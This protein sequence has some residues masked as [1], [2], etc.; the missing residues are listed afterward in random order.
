MRSIITR[1]TGPGKNAAPDAEDSPGNE[2]KTWFGSNQK[3]W[4][5]PRTQVTCAEAMKRLIDMKS[6]DAQRYANFLT[7]MN[8]KFWDAGDYLDC[9]AGTKNT[10]PTWVIVNAATKASDLC[11]LEPAKNRAAG[12]DSRLSRFKAAVGTEP[13]LS[14]AATFHAYYSALNNTAICTT[15]VVPEAERKEYKNINNGVGTATSPQIATRLGSTTVSDYKSF[16]YDIPSV[17][18]TGKEITLLYEVALKTDTTTITT[19][20]PPGGYAPSTSITTTDVHAMW[21]GSGGNLDCV[22]MAALLHQ[23]PYKSDWLKWMQEHKSAASSVASSTKKPSSE[24]LKPGE[25]SGSSGDGTTPK[26]EDQ[27]NCKIDYI[28]WFICPVVNTLASMS[29]GAR[30]QLINMLTVDAKSILGDTS[31]GSVYSYWSKIRDYANILFVV[32]FLF[33]IYSQMTGYGL[34]NY[35]IKRMLPKLIIGVIVVNASFYIC[36]LLVDLSNVVGSSAFNFV[37]TTAVG[38][39]PA[40]EWSNSDSGWINKI[41][42]LALVLTVGYFALAAVISMLLFVVITAV[43]TIFLLGVREAIIIMCIVLS[44]LAFVAMIMPNTEGLYKKWWSAFKAALMVYPMVGLVYGA[45]NL[46]ARILG[47]G[48]KESDIIMQSIVALLVFAPLLIVPKLVR[49]AVEIIG[50]GGAVAWLN[51]KMNKGRDRLTDKVGKWRENKLTSQFA[52]HRRE[53]AQLRNAQI[54]GGTY[55]GRGGI[56]N[57]RNWRSA[58]NRRL[59]A[60]SGDFGQKRKLGGSAAALAEDNERMKAASAWI[61]DNNMSSDRLAEIAT[62]FTRD[63]D[64]NIVPVDLS[65]ISSYQRRA[66]MQA[67]APH[68]TGK[69]AADLAIASAS[70]G[71]TSLQKEA[72]NA[73]G[74]SGAKKAPWVGGKQLEAIRQ[75]TYDEQAAMSDYIENNVSGEGLANAGAE[76][77]RKMRTFAQDAQNNGNNSYMESLSRARADLE[78]D[79]KR[80]GGLQTAVRREINDIPLPPNHGSGGGQGGSGG[81]GGRNQGGDPRSGGGGGQGGGGR[82]QGDGQ[83]GSGGGGGQGGGGRN[84]GGDPRS[85]GGGGQGDGQDGGN[86]SGSGGGTTTHNGQT[87]TQTSSGLYIPK[88]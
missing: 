86:Q 71:D 60:K 36:G 55:R 48:L 43:T 75:G 27:E 14:N 8:G 47:S 88:H 61:A 66:A 28:G 82:N 26:E 32:F 40:G 87:F 25:P 2:G 6:S 39:I 11:G 12:G 21:S 84:Q 30:A 7:G 51:K 67:L 83:G 68:M 58:A 31:E 73:I 17:D 38:D 19:P 63:K 50:I 46:A 20:V 34:D 37:S 74:Q 45:S 29:E 42:G 35:G 10:K 78:A 4:V 72:A 3:V 1:G 44:P 76:Q 9:E 23:D 13:T 33:V 56:A 62:G 52:K 49:S 81:G 15:R 85:G 77:I 69:Q 57:F 53:K 70:F 79:A 54:R 59:N 16:Y 22:T 80:A 64:D 65:G 24:Q 41:A 18:S 5:W